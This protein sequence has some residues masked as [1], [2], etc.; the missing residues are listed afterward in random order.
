MKVILLQD[1]DNLG[2]EGAVV[3]VKPGYGRNFLIP[4]GLAATA[5]TGRIKQWQEERRQMSRKLAQKREDAE[6]LAAELGNMEVV[7]KAKVGEERRI[8]GSITSQQVVDGLAAQGVRVDRRN[9]DLDEDIRML[10]VYTASV[11]LHSD[12]TGKVKVRVEP[13]G[14]LSSEETEGT[15]LA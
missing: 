12:V 14:M 9:V 11:K 10:G 7:I 3:D 8:F 1:V 4:R 5:T 6:A 13:E 2:D 15:D